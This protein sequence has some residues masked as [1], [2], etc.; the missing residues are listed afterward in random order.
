[1]PFDLTN[2]TPDAVAA[3]A[4]RAIADANAIVAGAVVARAPRSVGATLLPLDAAAG[5]IS[6]AL[7]SAGFMAYVHPDADVRVAGH[8]ASERLERWA[9]DLPFDP[10]VA[11][12]VTELAAT[13]EAAALT[14]ELARLLA[15]SVRDVRLAGHD[16]A[17]EAREEVRAAMARLVEIGVRF[18]QHIADVTDA[19]VV[20]D[21]DLAGLPDEY[22][23]GLA[24]DDDGRYRITMAYP[25]VVPFLEQARSRPRREELTRLFNN[26]AAD[27]NRELLAEAVAR[28]ERIA[29]LFGQ[30]SWAHHTMDEKMAHD[31]ETVDR[32]YEDLVPALT[33]KATDEI[34]VMARRLFADEGDEDLQSWDLRYYDTELRRTEFGVDN[35]EVATYFP[36]ER[37]LDGLLTITAE[38]FG[39][40]Y[41]PLPDEPVWHPDVR[42]YAVVDPARGG[43]IA[44]VHMDLHPREGKFSHAAAFTLVAGRRLADG[45]YRTPVSAI[46]ANLT[47]PTADRPSLLLHDEVVTLFHEFGHILHQTLTQAETVR[48]SGTSTE[49]DFV[50]APSQ[51]MEHWCWRPEVLSRFARHHVTD[52]PIPA[53]LVSQLV[54]ARDLNVAVLTLRQIQFGVLDMGFHGPRR[55][56]DGAR[57]DGDRDLDAILRRAERVAL[58]DHVEG[59]FFPASFG[60]LLGGYDAGYYGYLWAKVYGDDMFSRFAADGVTDAVVGGAYRQA[61]LERGGSRPATE[62]LEEFLGRAPN[63]EAFLAELGL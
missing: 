26:R 15:F 43:R 33:K 41:E 45:T 22:R 23:A 14:G 9:V 2:A 40:E 39:V 20:D 34:A 32:F 48:F 27:T 59:T 53:D 5:V 21:E 28:R 19:M 10:A 18:N 46:V 35:H 61:I 56:E 55:P 58:F 49:R 57:P 6:D 3:E 42:S 60:H 44:V 8:A 17:P 52:E 30:P 37:V 51:I 63:N 47:K 29:E 12:A 36:L 50:E 7:G 38:V 1:V 11:A 25:D 13:P 16:L 54:A 62:M 31:P 4:E 24:R